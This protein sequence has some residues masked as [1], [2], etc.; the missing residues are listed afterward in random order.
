MGEYV[1]TMEEVHDSI[2][3]GGLRIAGGRYG[4]DPRDAF[5]RW[6]AAHDAQVKAEALRDAAAMFRQRHN[7][8]EPDPWYWS[9]SADVLDAHADRIEGA[10]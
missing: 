4:D 6:L 10:P 7:D 2:A 1:P 9:D 5:D 8:G 3:R